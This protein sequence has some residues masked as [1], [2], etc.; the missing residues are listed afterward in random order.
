MLTFDAFTGI[1][2]VIPSE[3][4]T[5]KDLT[6][7]AN[8]DIGLTGE[9]RRR[10]GFS[11]VAEGCY[12]NLWQGP[13]FML[14]TSGGELVAIRDGSQVVLHP[15]LSGSRVWYC[16]L[17]DDRV[18][19]S[20]SQISGLTDGLTATPWGVPAPANAGV[21]TAVA[22]GLHPG[23]Y[24]YLLTHVRLSDGLEGGPTHGGALDLPDGGLLLTDLPQEDGYS[25][26]VYISGKDGDECFLAGNTAGDAFS[27]LGANETLQ[28][29]CR[30]LF[31]QPAPSGR[32][33]AFWRGRSLV[34]SG[35]VLYASAPNRWEAFDLRRDFK[36]FSA[37]ITMVQ[38]VAD[39]LYVGTEKALSFLAGTQW[40]AAAF[41]RVAAGHVVLGS[42]CEVP[43]EKL[44]FGDGTGSGRA[45]VCIVDGYLVGCFGGGSIA[46]L[47]QQRYRTEARE[48]ASAFRVVDGIPQY[49]AIPQ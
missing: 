24:R 18:A 48:V 10:R 17:P 4:L 32:L 49:L 33:V 21:S 14:A 8:V 34:A 9:V 27:Y 37:D 38:P 1:N 2:N 6:A 13:G 23:M 36:Q 3:R 35:N 47:S 7:A 28:L 40:D 43:G 16:N 31:D 11:L 45:A 42:G 19:F 25:I 30:T 26:N 15:A 39:G 12:K 44:K 5:E 29:P 22:G 41:A 20:N 46:Q